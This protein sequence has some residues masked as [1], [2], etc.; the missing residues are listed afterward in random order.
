MRLIDADALSE[1]IEALMNR[2]ATQGRTEVAEDYNFV[3][4]VLMTAETIDPE[5]LRPKGTWI[6]IDDDYT[7][8]EVIDDEQYVVLEC[9]CPFCGERIK[10]DRP[11]YCDNCGARMEG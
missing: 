10:K 9:E 8:D 7:W 6:V 3:L 11:N 2:Y 4:T 5:S 1:K